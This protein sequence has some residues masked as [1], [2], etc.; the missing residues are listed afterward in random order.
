[1]YNFVL[2][3]VAE[4]PSEE[5]T[6]SLVQRKPVH[7]MLIGGIECVTLDHGRHPYFGSQLVIEDL[8]QMRG[9]GAGFVELAGS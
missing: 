1:V 6:S 2:T 8:K 9:W 4:L 5:G 7:S 3:A